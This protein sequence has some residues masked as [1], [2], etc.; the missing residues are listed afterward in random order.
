MEQA[1]A[2]CVEGHLLAE[3]PEDLEVDPLDVEAALVFD[4]A[5]RAQV[6]GSFVAEV[7]VEEQAGL[8]QDG[9]GAGQDLGEADRDPS[10]RGRHGRPR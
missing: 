8:G 6:G 4:Q 1:V 3:V 10:G 2:R 9:L 5:A 7:G